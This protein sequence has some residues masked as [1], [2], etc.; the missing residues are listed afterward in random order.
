MKYLLDTN[1][2]I[3]LIKQKPTTVLAHFSTQDDPEA[4]YIAQGLTLYGDYAQYQRLYR[5]L[6]TVALGQAGRWH[7]YPPTH[8]SA[9]ETTQR[10]AATSSGNCPPIRA[11][12]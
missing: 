10:L 6:Y 11:L 9:R 12:S 3:Y 7:C 4:G 5:T 8:H 2:C 1:I